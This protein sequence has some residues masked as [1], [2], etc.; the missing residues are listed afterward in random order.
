MSEATFGVDVI[1]RIWSDSGEPLTVRQPP[2]LPGH[3]NI[4]AEGADAMSYWGPVNISLPKEMALLL[5]NSIIAC[6]KDAE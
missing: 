6:T 4:I 2:D 1:R 5:A 3:V